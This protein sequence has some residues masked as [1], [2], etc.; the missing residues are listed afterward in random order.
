MIQ[1]EGT[2]DGFEVSNKEHEVDKERSIVQEGC[3]F[4][5]AEESSLCED[6]LSW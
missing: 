5:S 2:V 1:W 3:I 4:I 6:Y